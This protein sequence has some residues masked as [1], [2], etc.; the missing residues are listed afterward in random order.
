MKKDTVE[1]LQSKEGANEGRPVPSSPP[2]AVHPQDLRK[3]ISWR[4]SS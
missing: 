4:S 2:L 3:G 1:L